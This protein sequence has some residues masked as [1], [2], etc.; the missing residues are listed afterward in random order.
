[1]FKGFGSGILKG[2]GVTIRHVFRRTITTQYPEKRLIVSRRIRG[3]VLAWSQDKCIG[4][5][6]CARSCPTRA[7]EIATIARG[8][9]GN[10]PAPCSHACPANVDAPRYI[11]CLAQG[12][13]GE[14]V[15]VIR[16]RIPFPSVCA[17]ICA[18]PCEY[19]C[20]RNHIDEA[21]AIRML[22]RYAVD[23]DSGVWKTRSKKAAPSGKKVAIIGAGPAGLTAAYYL[24]KL[25]GH[26]VTI[27]EALPKPG[28]MM[29]YGIPRYRLPEKILDSDIKEIEST[30]VK[31][32]TSTAIESPHSLL[33]N[34][35]QAVYIAIGAHQ[36]IEMGIEGEDNPRVF[37]GI[38]LLR[39]VSMG[40]KV[41]IG[42]RVAVIG[43]GNS[44]MDSARTAL[45]LGAKE[46]SIIYRRTRAEM[47]A[48]TEEI[49]EA[50]EEGV[51]FM[52]LVAPTKVRSKGEEL[53][54]ECVRMKLGAEDASGRR[55]PEPVP[56]SEFALELDSVIAAIG[57][58]PKLPEGFS[59]E[60][61]KGNIIKADCDTGE[62]GQAGIFAGGDAVMGPATVIQAIY[63]GRQ[64][65][66]S[67]DKYLGGSGNI[68]ETLA[69]PENII[70][71]Q[72]GPGEGFR[73]EFESIPHKQRT[74]S[75]DGTELGWDAAPM[76][77]ETARCLRCDLVYDVTK[78]QLNGGLCIYCGLCV[79]ACPFDALYM[80]YSYERSSY[81]LGEQTLQKEDLLTPDARKPSGY[82]HPEI[83]K[84]LPEQTLLI[85][86][87]P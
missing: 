82:Y 34:G 63:A 3:N 26:S 76:Q 21:I 78:Y 6:T 60:V 14:A 2:M 52:F 9:K 46:V 66:I 40:E 11:R 18:H 50:I 20:T 41:E 38:D 62:T 83:E 10:I 51:K 44:A 79:E 27:F 31:I 49:E 53:E 42:R 77:A 37:G 84:E 7:I 45:R 68:A 24:S 73:P 15:A 16:E 12:K 5:Y 86:T 32:E 23:N 75:F 61:S 85:N 17:Y 64:A 8:R 69:E 87:D 36:A 29:R 33:E 25:C 65:A 58:K 55:R 4:C 71:R 1:M 13:P 56:G 35:F 81:R 54:L 67:I 74:G 47:P 70:D 30:G 19:S 57:Q 48:S 72:G 43:G 28:G 59:M 80:G 39:R 22:K